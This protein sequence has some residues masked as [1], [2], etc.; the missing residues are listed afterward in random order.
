MLLVVAGQWR[1]WWGGHCYGPRLLTDAVPCLI[2]LT[3]PALDW[4]AR[5][6]ALRVAF[7]ALVAWSCFVQAVGAFCYP[8]SRWDETPVAVGSRPSRL[9]DWRDSPITRSLAAGP[10]LGPDRSALPKLRRLVSP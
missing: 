6:A 5:A 9:W 10:R 2:L 7:A 3:I 8:G 1:V 4:I